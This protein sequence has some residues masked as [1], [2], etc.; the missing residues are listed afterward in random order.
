MGDRASDDIEEKWVMYKNR[1][2]W[3]DLQPIKQND[4][5]H[6]VVK[7]AYS[8]DFSDVYDYFRGVVAVGELSERALILTEDAIQM[9]A[10]NYTVWQYRR[11]ILEHLKWDLQDELLFCREMIVVNPKNYQVW[12]HRRVIVE[13]LG[14]GSKELQL[15]KIIF[16]QDA[17]NY[18]AWE[19]RQWAL[20]T[21]GLY[22]GELEF[23]AELLEDDV[24]NNS[25][26]NHRYFVQTRTSGLT[27]QVLRSELAFTQ[28][29]IERL[30]DNESPWAY[31]K[32]LMND[33]SGDEE[34]IEA[35]WRDAQAWCWKLLKD[36]VSSLLPTLLSNSNT[37][38]Q[39]TS[40]DQLND[41]E[42]LS[43][44]SKLPSIPKGSISPH[45][46]IGVL[47]FV[48]HQLEKTED[49]RLKD[50]PLKIALQLCDTLAAEHDCIRVRY[51]NYVRR[52][53]LHEHRSSAATA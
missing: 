12:H 48:T 50:T 44:V 27:P 51:W 8:E 35:C 22:E 31:M 15:T 52:R 29:A 14:D 41:E 47:D 36:K 34:A 26:W 6:S 46:L 1:N 32:G 7:I 20:R 42:P 24:R 2:D 39:H 25:A 19:H 38:A 30:T 53:L 40:N 21:F 45:L 9:N 18:H 49:L 17:K 11:K 23:T 4:G 16:A 33:T 28:R 37:G 3:A 5:P 10:A 43:L 13:W